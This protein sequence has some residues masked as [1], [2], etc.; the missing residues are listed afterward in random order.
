[1]Y[2]IK[3]KRIKVYISSPYTNGDQLENTRRQMDITDEL[4]NGGF[5]P[6]TPLYSHFQH[7]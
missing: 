4:M 6:F 5:Y 7:I 2:N 1:M 3:D